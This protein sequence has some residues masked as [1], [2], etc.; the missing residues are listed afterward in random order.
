MKISI[1]LNEKEIKRPVK[2]T[3]HQQFVLITAF[4]E[5]DPEAALMQITGMGRKF[6]AA[7]DALEEMNMVALEDDGMSIT[8]SGIK[9]LKRHHLLDDSE[10]LTEK[11][12]NLVNEFSVELTLDAS[13]VD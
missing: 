2:L 8:K 5:E 12:S 13:I 7:V 9:S 4:N 6:I 3:K 10:T 11:A 1:L